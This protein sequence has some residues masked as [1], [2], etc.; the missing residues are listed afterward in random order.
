MDAG[1]LACCGPCLPGVCLGDG[2]KG[3][4][5]PV[6]VFGY[7]DNGGAVVEL[8]LNG[9]PSFLKS[10]MDSSLSGIGPLKRLFS[11]FLF[12]RENNKLMKI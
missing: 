3:V 5:E 1:P 6:G 2:K 7:G 9:F 11:I 12:K 8:V 4:P 10:G